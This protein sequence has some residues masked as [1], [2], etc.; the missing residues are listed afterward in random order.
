MFGARKPPG[1]ERF[2]RLLEGGNAGDRQRALRG[3]A[4]VGDRP[5]NHLVLTGFAGE[6]EVLLGQFPGALHRFATTGGEEDPVQVTRCVVRQPFGQ[7]DRRRGGGIG[8]Q[9][10]E[11]QLLG[12]LCGGL[13]QFGAPVSDLDHE[14]AREPVDITAALV[15]EDVDALT[16]GDDGRGGDIG[17]VPGEMPPHRWRL[18]LAAR[19]VER[20]CAT[21]V[22]VIA[23]PSCIAV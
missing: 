9:R 10:E 8:P 2:E 21:S 1:G 5:R 6:L 15:V 14:Q 16:A 4:V 22:V 18:A 7:L 3:G 23:C 11:G 19:S 13:G 12:L 20:D 17:T